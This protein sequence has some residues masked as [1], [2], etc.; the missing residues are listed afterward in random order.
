[1]PLVP[2]PGSQV[3][4][5]SWRMFLHRSG[6]RKWRSDA[7]ENRKQASANQT[8]RWKD[9]RVVFSYC[10]LL[11]S[12]LFYQGQGQRMKKFKTKI[13]HYRYSREWL[14]VSASFMKLKNSA[15]KRVELGGIA[16]R[17][18]EIWKW[19]WASSRVHTPGLALALVLQWYISC[20]VT[21]AARQAQ[22]C[23][24]LHISPEM[25]AGF[26]AL[27]EEN[28]CVINEAIYLKQGQLSFYPR[29]WR[30]LEP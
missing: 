6:C 17:W 26:T 10:V 12:V 9:E 3:L 21:L 22:C 11:S 19:L 2:T 24:T 30:T 25:D 23:C 13:R 16:L 28:A 14:P 1:M 7:S 29:S 15:W 5:G 4:R 8:W 27:K 18:H 20:Q